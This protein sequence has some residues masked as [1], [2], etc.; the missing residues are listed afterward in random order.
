MGG[1]LLIEVMRVC[2]I[3]IW[4]WPRDMYSIARDLGL[5]VHYL[6]GYGENI[7]FF[8]RDYRYQTLS[9]V[10]NVNG[11]WSFP[12]VKCMS[13]AEDVHWLRTDSMKAL[14]C[15]TRASAVYLLVDN[16]RHPLRH[17]VISITELTMKVA[18][19]GSRAIYMKVH[20]QVL[21][22]KVVAISRSRCLSVALI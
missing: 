14:C 6:P 12:E 11:A 3:Y 9:V 20:R 19:I 4:S 18:H 7:C 15:V 13:R 10:P 16:F 21:T 17:R 2:R 22:G 8:V 5:C 1:C